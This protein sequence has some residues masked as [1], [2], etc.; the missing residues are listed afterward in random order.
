MNYYKDTE[1]IGTD[2]SHKMQLQG[3][4]QTELANKT[5]ISQA[6]LSQYAKNKIALQKDTIKKIE[7]ALYTKL[8]FDD[9]EV[10]LKQ[11]IDD[12]YNFGY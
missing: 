7:Q 2:L 12:Y 5:G 8:K 4:T 9:K 6:H 11:R 10:V 3:I 1:F